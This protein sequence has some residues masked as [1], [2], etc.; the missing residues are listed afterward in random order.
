MLAKGG[1]DVNAAHNDGF[2]VLFLA[3]QNG[4][5]GVDWELIERGAD[6]NATHV[7]GSTALMFPAGNGHDGVV[8][9]LIG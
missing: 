8:R 5:V 7:N 3:T 4:H 1:A 2:T 6:V 9:E